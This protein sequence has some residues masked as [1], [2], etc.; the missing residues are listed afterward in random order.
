MS[1]ELREEVSR[2]YFKQIT[3]LLKYQPPDNVEYMNTYQIRQALY[4]IM[5]LCAFVDIYKAQE[6][7]KRKRENLNDK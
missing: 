5:D 4:K 3:E 1:K 7:I 2:V 6:E